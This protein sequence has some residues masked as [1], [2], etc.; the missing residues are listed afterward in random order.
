MKIV[1]CGCGPGVLGLRLLQAFPGSHI[2][3]FEVDPL[4]VEVARRNAQ[5]SELGERYEVSERSIMKTDL[6]S[7]TFDFAITRLVLEHLSDPVGAAR[8]VYR[9][10]KHGGKAVF[11]DNDFEFHMRTYPDIPE[12]RDLYNA[13]CNARQ[14]EGGNPRIG[15]ELPGILR[16]AGFSNVDLQIV[17]A[18]SEIVGDEIFLQS[19]GSGIPVQLVKDGYLT[20]EVYSKIAL[21][22]NRLLKT[23]GHSIFRQLFVSA[24]E[25]DSAIPFAVDKDKK[26]YVQSELGKRVTKDVPA[27]ESLRGAVSG[28]D[29]IYEGP[30][31]PTEKKVAEIWQEILCRE[32]V[33]INENF[34]EAGGSSILAPEIVVLLEKEFSQ[35]LSVVDL[36]DY[37]T[38]AL[39]AKRVQPKEEDK[40][41]L[42]SSERQRIRYERMQERRRSI[43]RMRSQKDG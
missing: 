40:E 9:I 1:E 22:W 37:P 36:F 28:D 7:D 29:R 17:G 4:L 23:E 24:G 12:L 21:K 5:L 43:S 16:L 30:R 8:E 38:I 15:R 6:P 41:H 42:S 19:E 10:L 26:S 31:N 20:S 34:F 18:H 3:A 13:Y 32:R 39:L 14:R 27:K 25:K 2:T 33:G 35:E 11:I